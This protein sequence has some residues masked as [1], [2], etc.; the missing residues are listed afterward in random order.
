MTQ[1]R[2]RVQTGALLAGAI[3]PSW[4]RAA[5]RE[6]GPRRVDLGDAAHRA[7]AAAAVQ[8]Q[9]GYQA[10]SVQTIGRVGGWEGVAGAGGRGACAR[11]ER[12]SEA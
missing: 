9:R 4:R 3:P 6:H 10:L 8:A 11:G 7:V 1:M 5:S 12:F 2:R